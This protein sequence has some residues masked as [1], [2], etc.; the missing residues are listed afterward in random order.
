[1]P[2]YPCNCIYKEITP[3]KS[4]IFQAELAHENDA[5]WSTRIDV[6][7]GCAAWGYTKEEALQAIQDAAE[8]YIEDMIEAGETFP[9]Q[10]VVLVE[11]PV[12]TVTHNVK[13]PLVDVP[14]TSVDMM[15]RP[16]GM[17]FI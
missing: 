15:R 2:C 11:A 3:T 13:S 6:L 7:S 14:L 9:S 8:A 5:C 12:V 17:D 4:Y 1:M 10:G 16:S